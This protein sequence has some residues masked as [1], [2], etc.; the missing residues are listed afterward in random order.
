MEI[1]S[2]ESHRHSGG[3]GEKRVFRFDGKAFQSIISKLLQEK[4][5]RCGNFDTR[6]K[7]TNHAGKTM[8]LGVLR[9]PVIT[10]GAIM[11]WTSQTM[12]KFDKLPE[13]CFWLCL[14]VET[15]NLK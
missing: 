6:T 9:V 2:S 3:F 15:L 11:D 5:W 12:I 14:H 1:R 7:K 4:H 8:K 13:H 10:T